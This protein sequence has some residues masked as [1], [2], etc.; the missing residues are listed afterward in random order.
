MALLWDEARRHV[1]GDLAALAC[2]AQT[3]CRRRRLLGE[4]KEGN[5]ATAGPRGG[6]GVG[7]WLRAKGKLQTPG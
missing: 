3:S 4:T 6:G 2:C 7:E 5:G 1:L